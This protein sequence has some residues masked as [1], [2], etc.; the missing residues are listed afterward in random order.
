MKEIYLN[1]L[2]EEQIEVIKLIGFEAFLKLCN[3][4]SGESIYFPKM[5]TAKTIERNNKIRAEYN[6]KNISYLSK[7]Y[8][9]CE[10]QVRRIISS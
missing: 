7:K 2:N 3:Y 10:R 9:I 6:G 4:F 5:K 1:N 8:N